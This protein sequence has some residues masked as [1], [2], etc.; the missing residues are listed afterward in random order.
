M[1][2][3]VFNGA[4]S[5]IVLPVSLEQCG[6]E[7]DGQIMVVHLVVIRKVLHAETQAVKKKHTS[8]C[9]NTYSGRGDKMVSV[10]VYQFSPVE[11]LDKG[12]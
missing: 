6:T 5:G 1:L 10:T 8:L 9:T 12:L 3:E 11:M 7:H 2:N 4:A